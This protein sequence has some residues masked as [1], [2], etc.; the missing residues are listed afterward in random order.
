MIAT[1]GL[2]R[3]TAGAP[4]ELYLRSAN[5]GNVAEPAVRHRLEL[6]DLTAN[7]ITHVALGAAVTVPVA[8]GTSTIVHVVAPV[9]AAASGDRR[10]VVAIA[11][12]DADGRRVALPDDAAA[13]DAFFDL[14]SRLPNV[15]VREFVVT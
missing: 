11:D 14:A 3:L 2:D 5:T 15:A 6:L 1:H 9:P 4:N 7:P 12:V 10:F 13:L 8:A